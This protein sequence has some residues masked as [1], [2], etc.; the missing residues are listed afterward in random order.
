MDVQMPV[1]D[2]YTATTEIR[3]IEAK[4]GRRTPIIALTAYALTDERENCFNS[5]MDDYLSK[6]ISPVALQEM[7]DRFVRQ[8]GNSIECIDKISNLV[9]TSERS[10]IPR[11][12]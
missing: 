7:L 1:M 2:G 9:D 12:E 3:R 6:P 11:K 5:G 10:T 8:S 4:Q